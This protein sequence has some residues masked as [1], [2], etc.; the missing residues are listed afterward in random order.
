MSPHVSREQ[1]VG[2]LAIAAI[3]AFGYFRLAKIP[4]GEQPPRLTPKACAGRPAVPSNRPVEKAN[5]P[6]F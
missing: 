4:R 3:A 2:L 5:F 6:V 1:S